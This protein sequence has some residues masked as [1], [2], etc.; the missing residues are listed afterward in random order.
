MAEIDQCECAAVR[1]RSSTEVISSRSRSLFELAVARNWSKVHTLHDRINDGAATFWLSIGCS[2]RSPPIYHRRRY[3]LP[4]VFNPRHRNVN[5]IP[6]FS[7]PSSFRFLLVLINSI[8]F[9]YDTYR[10][11]ACPYRRSGLSTVISFNV[12]KHK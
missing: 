5:I 8:S 1:S 6:S 7:S 9:S 4:I 2:S 11:V 12:A 3:P 10:V